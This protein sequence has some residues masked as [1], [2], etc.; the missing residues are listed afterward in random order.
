ML[1]Q[2]DQTFGLA[3][4]AWGFLGLLCGFLRLSFSSSVDVL[5]LLLCVYRLMQ[6]TAEGKK[7]YGASAFNVASWSLYHALKATKGNPNLGSK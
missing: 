3:D 6:S 5:W 7:V 2:A 1:L 4:Y